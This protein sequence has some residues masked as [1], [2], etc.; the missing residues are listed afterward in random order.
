MARTGMRNEYKSHDIHDKPLVMS[1]GNTRTSIGVGYILNNDTHLPLWFSY[2]AKLF[3]LC[4]V[5]FVSSMC[6]WS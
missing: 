4:S 3:E 1:D 6:T 5:M 2:D